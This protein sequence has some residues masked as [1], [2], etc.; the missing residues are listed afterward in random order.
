LYI[1]T[2]ISLTASYHGSYQ[3][4]W[5]YVGEYGLPSFRALRVVWDFV[6][7]PSHSN[8]K[9][10]CYEKRA[11]EVFAKKPITRL[12]EVNSNGIVFKK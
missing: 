11:L 12:A 6:E 1:A 9:N 10:W 7:L 3:L 8:G 4:M 5:S 2:Y